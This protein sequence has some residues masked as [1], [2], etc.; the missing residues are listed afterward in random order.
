PERL[1][2]F[3]ASRNRGVADKWQKKIESHSAYGSS[4][5]EL[6]AANE[7]QNVI[8]GRLRCPS[9]ISESRNRLSAHRSHWIGHAG[10]K[11]RNTFLAAS[12]SQFQNGAFPHIRMGIAK[13]MNQRAKRILV[14]PAGDDAQRFQAHL[15]G[16]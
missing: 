4:V 15:H 9:E 10:Y 8:R 5:A 6:V 11:G 14:S 2:D 12:A 16:L 3:A 1:R 13:D 7:I